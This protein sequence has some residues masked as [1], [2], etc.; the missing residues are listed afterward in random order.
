VLAAGAASTIG[1]ERQSW[2]TLRDVPYRNNVAQE[3]STQDGVK[4]V[5]KLLETFPGSIVAVLDRRGY[6]LNGA[7]VDLPQVWTRQ[8]AESLASALD[9]RLTLNGAGAILGP[10]LLKDQ[11]A[12]QFNQVNWRSW[13]IN[14]RR[15]LELIAKAFTR[16]EDLSEAGQSVVGRVGSHQKFGSGLSGKQ[17]WVKADFIIEIRRVSDESGMPI[18]LPISPA[19]VLVPEDETV[20]KDSPLRFTAPS[21]KAIEFVKP[22]V[23]YLRGFLNEAAKELGIRYAI[24]QRFEEMPLAVFGKFDDRQVREILQVLTKVETPG[25]LVADETQLEQQRLKAVPELVRAL[26]AAASPDRLDLIQ[27]LRSRSQWTLREIAELSPILA[28][29]MQGPFDNASVEQWGNEPATV[30]ISGAT[31]VGPVGSMSSKIYLSRK[32]QL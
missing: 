29:G 19:D 27:K 24:D 28:R 12:S 26:E 21:G 2:T 9:R 8:D 14:H 25:F 22:E 31:Y 10:N 7:K 18:L 13:M 15:D 17:I 32:L 4:D 23:M 5:L 3:L 6:F 11:S 30:A 20:V 16:I 1:Q